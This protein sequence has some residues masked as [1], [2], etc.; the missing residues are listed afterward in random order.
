MEPATTS[1][2]GT[3]KDVYSIINEKIIECLERQSVPWQQSWTNGGL[4][5]NIISKRYYRGINVPLLAMEGYE[6]N[7][8]VTFQ[9]LKSIGGKIRKGEKGHIVVYWNRVEK[10]IEQVDEP[11]AQKDKKKA[12]L[13][14]YY[15]FNI[16]QCENIPEKYLPATRE[17]EAIP[18]CESIVTGMPQCPPIRHKEQKAF[19]HPADDYVNMPKKRS[20]KSDAAYYSTLFHE[21]MHSTGHASRLS[22][23]GV[24]GTAEFGGEAYSQEEL[25]A[26]IGA[27]YLQSHTGITSEFDSS[28][29][30][31]QGWL[32]KLKNDKR[33]IF[34]AFTAAQRAIDFI[35]NVTTV[36]EDLAEQE[37]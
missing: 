33:F 4:P 30:Y 8:F 36:Q 28:A 21:L 24:T 14:Y 12:V 9:Q 7:L 22:R 16:S 27:C 13:R 10:S 11:D 5:Q 29:S 3:A 20:F 6:H 2:V 25:I 23:S 34:I 26:E 17:A 35:L 31:I 1:R 32:T 37:E 19:Y 18:S 15:V